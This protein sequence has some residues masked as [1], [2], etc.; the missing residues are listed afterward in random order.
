MI[1]AIV[2][3]YCGEEQLV[4]VL[5]VETECVNCEVTNRLSI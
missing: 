3:E 1:P 4:S 2:C 5:T